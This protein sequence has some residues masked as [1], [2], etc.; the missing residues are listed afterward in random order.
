[1]K[2]T[3][4]GAIE[5]SMSRELQN[6]EREHPYVRHEPCFGQEGDA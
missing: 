2:F 5:R 4:G 6:Y 3:R 1:M